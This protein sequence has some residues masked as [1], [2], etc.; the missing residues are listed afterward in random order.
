MSV[1]DAW[2]CLSLT[3]SLPG[4]KSES[5]HTQLAT[6]SRRARIGLLVGH[7]IPGRDTPSHLTPVP[8][9]VRRSSA[10]AGLQHAQACCHRGRGSRK[11]DVD[12]WIAFRIFQ[13][14]RSLLKPATK[15]CQWCT[16]SPPCNS[17]SI[18]RLSAG[19]GGVQSPDQRASPTDTGGWNLRSCFSWVTP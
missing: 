14:G 7:A 4:L 19:V 18:S 15:G 11:M 8:S 16:P 6:P 13:A 12:E 5:L 1:S 10:P 9:I 17:I 2:S 3:E